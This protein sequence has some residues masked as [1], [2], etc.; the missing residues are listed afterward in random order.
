MNFLRLALWLFAASI[1]L[2]QS[3][4]QGQEPF[5]SQ[6]QSSQ[7][8][9]PSAE[10]DLVIRQGIVYDGSGSPPFVGDIGLKGDSLAAIAPSLPGQAQREIQAKGLA[11][12]PGFI[13]ML[14]WA[15]ESLIVDGR[16]QSDIRQGVTLEVFG[17]GR[18]MGPINEAM[19]RELIRSQ[20]T[21]RY[22]VPWTT[23]GEYLEH[24]VSRGV[25]PNVASFVGATTVRMYL[26]GHSLRPPSARELEGM[27]QLVRQ[28]MEEGA[29][30]LASALIYAPGA[31]ADTKELIALAE[32]ASQYDGLY[33][34][35]IRNEG[36]RLLDALDEFIRIAEKAG[37]RAEIYHLKAAGRENWDKMDEVIA[38]I[39]A[40]R[41]KGL[42]VTANMYVYDASSASLDV[43]LP[44]WVHKGG[45][46][47]MLRRLR[48]KEIR[49]RILRGL[50]I[51]EPE[52]IR[53]LNLRKDS[54][55]PLA[56][57]S[58]KEV[59]ELWNMTPEEALLQLVLKDGGGVRML[60]F[61][62]SE[63]NIRKQ[64]R[65]PWVSF[66]SDG[67]SFSTEGPFLRFNT[68]PRA[69]GN[70]AR[71]LGRYVRDEGLMTLEEAVRKLTSLPASNLRL[72]KRG[73]LKPGYF[74]DIVIFDPAQ[75]RDNA[76]Y[77]QPHRYANGVVHVFVNGVQ[78]LRDGHHT[79]AKPG[80]VVR[81]PG[82]KA[83]LS[84]LRNRGKQ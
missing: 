17:E 24:L 18:S 20:G 38:R 70:F 26:L 6:D 42:Q 16:S 5:Q 9:T 74:A 3:V 48:D 1:L 11:V 71:L 40:A 37:V 10:Y 46:E 8:S 7:E 30:G 51:R 65:L 63:E 64:I 14:S 13:N 77:E 21:L 56:G 35:H 29:M 33:I 44:P 25:S 80:R 66:G 49:R 47:A 68:H 61:T 27:R 22:D 72:Q 75:I 23:L 31:Y 60:R 83:K 79:G 73:A 28:A 52:G 34:S 45:P 54:L 15:T 67:G 82:F 62:M 81:G 19:R 43:L 84:A 32:V 2:R 69:F 55:K 58:L 59:A 50:R 53:L 4:A 41:K 78:V 36:G 12:A 76:T 39:E 57:K